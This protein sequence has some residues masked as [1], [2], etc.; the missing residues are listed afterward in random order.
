M[1][2]ILLA[3]TET[4]LRIQ[5][6]CGKASS[7]STSPPATTNVCCCS[8][9]L[10]TAAL[11]FTIAEG[12]LQIL[13]RQ[14]GC[15]QDGRERVRPSTHLT[16]AFHSNSAASLQCFSA[17]LSFYLFSVSVCH[18]KLNALAVLGLKWFNA[19]LLRWEIMVLL[20]ASSSSQ[21]C[22]ELHGEWCKMV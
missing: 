10:K 15:S 1:K 19:S 20:C 18:Q 6:I 14:K 9:Y 5:L 12:W 16:P 17:S 11:F 13:H 3:G 7:C 4:Q 2:R 22:V 8:S 21:P